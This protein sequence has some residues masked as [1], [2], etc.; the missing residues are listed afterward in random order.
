MKRGLT[1]L[2]GVSEAR[3]RVAY[4]DCLRKGVFTGERGGRRGMQMGEVL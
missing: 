1:G 3:V 2:Y 4:Q